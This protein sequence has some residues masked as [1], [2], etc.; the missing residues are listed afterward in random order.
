MH[1]SISMPLD[2]EKATP[3]YA[4]LSQIK[5]VPSAKSF[6]IPYIQRKEVM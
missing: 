5:V 6:L 4:Y 2:E 3:E 1:Q